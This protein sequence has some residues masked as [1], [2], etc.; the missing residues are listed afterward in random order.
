MEH[1]GERFCFQASDFRRPVQ[2]SDSQDILE[3]LVQ[4]PAV[5]LLYSCGE[6]A[7]VLSSVIWFSM[8]HFPS[9][10]TLQ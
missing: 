5:T 4:G 1:E 8:T 9:L 7:N 2:E 10:F 6:V 3:D